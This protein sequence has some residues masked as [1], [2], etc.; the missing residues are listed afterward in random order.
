M[1]DQNKNA[2]LAAPPETIQTAISDVSGREQ[3]LDSQKIESDAAPV[4]TAPY[5]E[6]LRLEKWCRLLK[7]EKKRLRLAENKLKEERAQF[8]MEQRVR[9][10]DLEEFREREENLKRYETV[11]RET[12]SRIDLERL[13]AAEEKL[14][15]SGQSGTQAECSSIV[16]WKRFARATELFEIEKGI[17]REDR[18][19]LREWEQT[20]KLRE[21][22]LKAREEKLVERE[23]RLENE[24]QERSKL[25]AAHA[26]KTANSVPLSFMRSLTRS[27]FATARAVLGHKG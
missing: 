10:Q 14:K 5:H 12:Q 19:A 9:A 8:S 4:G 24:A 2:P 15:H 11:L 16:E 23:H 20:L 6:R 22:T 7:Q 27:P 3:I 25:S 18:L 13:E 1:Q 21:S 26:E 17:L